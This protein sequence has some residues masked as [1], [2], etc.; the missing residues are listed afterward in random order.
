LAAAP[1]RTASVA[2]C[3]ALDEPAQALS[4]LNTGM[5]PNPAAA[6]TTW[7]TTATWPVTS[8]PRALATMAISISSRDTPASSSASST[9]WRAR[10]FSDRSGN[11]PNGV[12]PTPVTAT[13]I[14]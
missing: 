3:R 12:R 8:A 7:P 9:A 11:L 5:P 6:S 10:S 14:V 2:R 1:E 4:T 13:C